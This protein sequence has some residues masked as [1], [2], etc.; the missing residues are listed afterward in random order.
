[1]RLWTCQPWSVVE[2]VVKD[3]SFVCNP[4]KSTYINDK[5]FREAYEWL[6][7]QMIKKLVNQ[8]TMQY[9]LFGPGI[10][11]VEKC[12]ILLNGTIWEI[13]KLMYG[14]S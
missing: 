8:I 1:M 6:I 10:L 9:I 7:Q 14:L 13:L 4:K 11:L 5:I 12:L 3:G 2:K